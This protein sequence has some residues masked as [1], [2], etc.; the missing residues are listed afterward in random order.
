MEKLENYFRVKGCDIVRVE[1]FVPN[2][3]AYAFYTKLQYHD[4]MIDM[5]KRL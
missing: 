2:V 3:G 4:R 1:C 5:V